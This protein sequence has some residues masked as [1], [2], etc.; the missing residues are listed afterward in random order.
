MS[1]TFNNKQL[2]Q[3]ER[4]AMVS[5]ECAE[6][7]QIKEKIM[8]HGLNSYNPFDPNKVTNHVLFRNEI[9]DLVAMIQILQEHKDIDLIQQW[10][11]NQ[12]KRNKYKYTHHQGSLKEW[13][14]IE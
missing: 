4:L 9:L 10:E 12:I 14:I 2:A 13:L 5:E 3:M 6:V 7:I 11:L 8:R 1:Q